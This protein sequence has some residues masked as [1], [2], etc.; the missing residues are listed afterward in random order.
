VITLGSI[1]G[2][3]TGAAGFTMIEVVC[4]LALMIFLFGGIYGIAN[5]M[6][7]LCRSSSDARTMELRLNNL[8]A[9]L[10]GGF[11]AL[12]RGATFELTSDGKLT[13]HDA[14]GV[15][16]WAGAL[17]VGGTVV[18]KI[19]DDPVRKGRSRLMLEHWRE[20]KTTGRRLLGRLK[21]LNDLESAGWRLLNLKTSEW[22]GLWFPAQGRPALAEFTFRMAGDSESQR[23][24]F[25][26]PFFPSLQPE[27]PVASPAR[28]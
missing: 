19:E 3:R 7:T 18:M 2:R 14:P 24:V 13:L 5:G 25:S 27:M 16:S 10:R 20:S 6:L 4:A 22:E 12:P 15:L 23:M 17:D 21:I 1:R 26:I 28:P 8:D 11:E 9:L